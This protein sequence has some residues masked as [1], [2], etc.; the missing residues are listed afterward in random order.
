[1]THRADY[2][3][4]FIFY[5]FS[6]RIKYKKQPTKPAQFLVNV[7]EALNGGKSLNFIQKNVFISNKNDQSCSQFLIAMDKYA[8][9]WIKTMVEQ[10]YPQITV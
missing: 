9:I 8:G 2:Q 1:M 7:T 10:E 4:C 3:F 5:P 6:I